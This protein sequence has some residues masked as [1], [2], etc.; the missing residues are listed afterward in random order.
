MSNYAE[1]KIPDYDKIR[2]QN[3]F[4]HY[5][6]L[7]CKEILDINGRSYKKKQKNQEEVLQHD[8]M[9]RLLRHETN[10]YACI[11]RMVDNP[12]PLI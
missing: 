2:F 12:R 3:S 1:A 6:S 5:F 8:L 7:I 9:N 11:Q 10:I 4:C